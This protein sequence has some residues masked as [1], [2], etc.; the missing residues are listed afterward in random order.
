MGA[1]QENKKENS[2]MN[3]SLSENLQSI[4]QILNGYSVE[5]LTVGGA[6]VSLL[7][8]DRWSTD[9]SGKQANVVD[10]DFWYNPIYTNYFKLLEVLEKLG[11]DMSRVKKEKS[12]DPHKSFFRLERDKFTL[13]FL[14]VMPGLPRFREVYTAR[15]TAKLGDIEVPYISYDYLIQSKQALGRL[16]DLE[17]IRQLR[18]KRSDPDQDPSSSRHRP[19]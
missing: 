15:E 9:T 16:K 18:L 6:A 2:K 12:P 1:D 3:P 10:L 11:Q 7:G 8:Y 14:P 4:C 13:D 19:S 5:Y 17:D